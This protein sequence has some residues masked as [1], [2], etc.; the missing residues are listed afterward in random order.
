MIREYLR[1][2]AKVGV[3]LFCVWHMAAVGLYSIPGDAKDPVAAWLCAHAVPRVTKYLLLTSQW[4]QWNL[5]APN[6]LRRIVFYRVETSNAD[7]DWAY[8]ASVN[9]DT[10]G[11]WRHA[12]RF[13]LLGQALEENT[14]RPELAERA[15]QVFCREYGLEPGAGIRIWH[16]ITIVPYVH[17]SPGKAWWDSWKPVFEPSLAVD[18]VCQP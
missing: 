1:T 16:E 6:P 17:P 5:F 8:V 18:T 11:P 3:A 12:V 10:Y 4:Q 14:T 13:K 2:F 9:A 7:G 15:A